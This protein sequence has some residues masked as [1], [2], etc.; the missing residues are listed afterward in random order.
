MKVT[1]DYGR[2]G[3][4][5][6]LPDD[7]T[8]GPLAIRDAAPLADPATGLANALR[9]PIGA[10]PLSELAQ[11]RQSACIVICDITRPVPNKL[12]L[13]QVLRTL[14][15]AGIPRKGILILVATGLHRPNEGA[16]LVEMVGA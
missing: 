5:V 2:T 16:E 14:E 10:R 15:E 1:L 6:N 11:G 12:I 13:P 8:I 4:E 3:L 9:K 7:R